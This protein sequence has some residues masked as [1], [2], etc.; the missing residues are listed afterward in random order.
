MTAP[1]NYCYRRSRPCTLFNWDNESSKVPR[2]LQ[3]AI[4]KVFFFFSATSFIVFSSYAYPHVATQ[5]WIPSRVASCKGSFACIDHSATRMPYAIRM[6]T[7]GNLL[8]NPPKWLSIN[9]KMLW[10]NKMTFSHGSFTDKA[11]AQFQKTPPMKKLWKNEHE[12]DSQVC[13]CNGCN[14]HICRQRD[15]NQLTSWAPNI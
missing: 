1:R 4:L 10:L 13:R 5:L 8:R 15:C 7:H 14:A 12:L 11:T 9:G 3:Q 6:H 2:L